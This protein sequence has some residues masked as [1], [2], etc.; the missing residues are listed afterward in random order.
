MAHTHLLLKFYEDNGL[1]EKTIKTL[2]NEKK[3]EG[4]TY[5]YQPFTNDIYTLSIFSKDE[6]SFEKKRDQ[7]IE[8]LQNITEYLSISYDS[9]TKQYIEKIG[10]TIYDL[11][12]Q[13]RTLIEFVFLKKFKSSW[14]DSFHIKGHDRKSKRGETI[15][16]LNN[17]LDD[18]DF[19]K[20][21]QFV[22]DQITLMDQ[23]IQKKF[24]SLE[25]SIIAID[26]SSDLEKIKESI[27]KKVNELLNTSTKNNQNYKYTDF[28]N[29]LTPLLAAD[30]ERLYELRNLWAHNIALMTRTEYERYQRLYQSV[31][32]NIRTEITV[33][34]LFSEDE[35]KFV[36]VGGTKEEHTFKITLYKSNFEGRAIIHLKGKFVNDDGQNIS[37]K[38]SSVTYQDLFTLYKKI[39]EVAE[40]EEK[41]LEVNSFF[42]YNPFLERELIKLG[43]DI[44]SKFEELGNK[45]SQIQEFLSTTTGYEVLTNDIKV[46]MNEDVD[47]Y[48]REIFKKKS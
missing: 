19:V 7:L 23:E 31:L 17:P 33:S 34:S 25:Q 29:H 27:T 30:W 13:F 5:K 2:L 40:D 18:L 47:K 36:D 39:L 44:A 22:A 28:Y 42:E 41:L 35:V 14:A 20:L 38:K 4:I 37:F 8:Y 11:E 16:R 1:D 15:T 46:I 21:S 12:R 3:F 10:E 43:D 48:L 32:K 26:A 24:K 9:M 45:K 6:Q